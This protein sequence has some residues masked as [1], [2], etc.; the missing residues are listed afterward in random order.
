MRAEAPRV[1]W[2]AI[3][4]R[5]RVNIQQD[6]IKMQIIQLVVVGEGQG[7]A[8]PGPGKLVVLAK[9]LAEE[10]G[11]LRY[12]GS[13]GPGVGDTLMTLVARGQ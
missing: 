3:Q 13:W 6:L 5:L 2:F 9:D 4:P 1:V 7:S 10:Q 8:S 12:V 11:M